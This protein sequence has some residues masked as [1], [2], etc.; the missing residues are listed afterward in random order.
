MATVVVDQPPQ[1]V[2]LD[3]LADSIDAQMVML[4]RNVA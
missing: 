3:D 4:D 2:A 1:L